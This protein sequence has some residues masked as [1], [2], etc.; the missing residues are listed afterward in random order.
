MGTRGRKSAN[1]LSLLVIDT[2]RQR[3]TPPEF[4]T[5]KQREIFHAIVDNSDPKAFR[6]AELRC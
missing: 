6:R 3:L 5:E 2:Q 1:E 4:L